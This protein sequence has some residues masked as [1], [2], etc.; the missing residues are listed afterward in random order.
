MTFSAVADTVK[1]TTTSYTS[2]STRNNNNSHIIHH[3][4]VMY[5][6]D[7]H[8]SLLLLKN[9]N[10]AVTKIMASY[11]SNNNPLLCVQSNDVSVRLQLISYVYSTTSNIVQAPFHELPSAFHNGII[12]TN[13][14][15]VSSAAV[16]IMTTIFNGRTSNND[17]DLYFDTVF[18]TPSLVYND[19]D[20]DSFGRVTTTIPSH[21]I[22]QGSVSYLALLQILLYDQQD[23]LS[24]FKNKNCQFGMNMHDNNDNTAVPV[25]TK[26]SSA[27]YNGGSSGGNNFASAITMTTQVYS[28]LP[29]PS[30]IIPSN[31]SPSSSNNGIGNNLLFISNATSNTVE[32]AAPVVMVEP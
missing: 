8:N 19:N 21:I 1:R 2:V 27:I 4:S 11:H 25:I 30:T 13:N 18:D 5:F 12:A 14:D 16:T 10:T 7:Q 22:D 6:Y 26:I 32:M 9:N 29:L 31:S 3:G 17:F 20:N 15:A 24:L 23:V 28:S